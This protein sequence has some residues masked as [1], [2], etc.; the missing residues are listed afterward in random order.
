MLKYAARRLLQMI[1]TVLGVVL[2][3]FVLFNLVGGSP[4]RMAL[5]EKAS[6]R[7]VEEFDE[8]N[9]FNKPVLFGTRIRTLALQDADFAMGAGLWSSVSNAAFVAAAGGER[10]HLVCHGIPVPPLA[11]PLRPEVGYEW[12][13]TWRLPGGAWRTDRVMLPPGAAAGSLDAAL[14]PGAREIHL[15]GVKLRRVVARPWDSQLVHYLAQVARFDFGKSTGENLPVVQLLRDGLRPTMML[16]APILAVELVVSV[17][18]GLLCAFFRGRF[19]DRLMVFVSVALMSINYLVW[20]VVGQYLLAYRQGWFPVWGFESWAYLMLPVLVGVVSGLGGDVRFYRT[21]MLDEIY[22]D[23]VR[24]A[25]AKGVSRSG[26]LFRHVLRNAMVPIVTNVMLAIPFLYTGSL[27][28]E[29]YFGIPGIGYLSV[30]AINSS[31]PAVIR[32]VVLIGSLLYVLVGTLGDILS[33]LFDPRIKL[34]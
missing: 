20:I 1:P 28:L 29:S 17:T 7:Q 4:G 33:A 14:P 34:S 31:D 5:G 18:M 10:G 12:S 32:A 6:P 22:K 16:A 15:S 30:N 13:L 19:L 3:T 2:I 27:L 23:Y 21:V 8:A 25:F 9:G 24:T 26:V 11:F